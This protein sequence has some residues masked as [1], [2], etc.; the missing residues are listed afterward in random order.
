MPK[1]TPYRHLAHLSSFHSSPL[2][3]LTLATYRRKPLLSHPVVHATLKEM[4]TLAAEKNGWFVGHYVIMPDHIHLFARSSLT[5]YTLAD[6]VKL[7]KSVSA[8]RWQKELG[9]EAPIWQ[10]EYFDRYLRSSENYS[11]KWAYVQLNPVRAKLV[12]REDQW[13][14][15]GRIFDLQF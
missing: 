14:Y 6:W 15:Q 10:E 13:P 3:F 2:L 11:D 7:L 9:Y 1:S 5:A 8:R 12:E 4:W